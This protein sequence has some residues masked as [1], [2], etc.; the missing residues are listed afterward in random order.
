[1]DPYR[2]AVQRIMVSLLRFVRRP[3]GPPK[4]VVFS[5]LFGYS[6][7]FSDQHYEK[8]DRTDFIY[9][10]DDKS[11]RSKLWTFRYVT[12]AFSGRFGPPR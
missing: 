4:R 8:D 2:T 9:F 10:T 3:A 5:C 11:L 1:M 6:E 12:P 7:A